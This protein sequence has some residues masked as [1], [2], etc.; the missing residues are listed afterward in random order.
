M[1]DV[2]EQENGA[3]GANDVT[4]MIKVIVMK[5]G[6]NNSVQKGLAMALKRFQHKFDLTYISLGKEQNFCLLDYH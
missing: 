2:A 4:K 1:D 6:N 3:G 5:S